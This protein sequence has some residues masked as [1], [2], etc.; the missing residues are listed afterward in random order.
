[1]VPQASSPTAQQA[2][3]V[4]F[5]TPTTLVPGAFTEFGLLLPPGTPDGLPAFLVAGTEGVGAGACPPWLDGACLDLAGTPVAALDEPVEDSEV[6]WE[7]RLP[8]TVSAPEITVQAVV[9]AP[10]GP[11][12]SAP[13]TIPVQGNTPPT[14]AT[15]DHP[16]VFVSQAPSLAGEFQINDLHGN[17]LGDAPATDQPVGG[18]LYRI[19]PGSDSPVDLLGL[20]EVAVRN[21][22]V[23]WDGTTILFSMK[24]GPL[25]NWQLYEVDADGTDLRRVVETP[26]NETEPLYLPDGRILFASDRLKILDPYEH[27]PVGQLFV[28]DPDGSNVQ[29]LT[30]DLGGDTTP[31]VL[32]DGRI[33]FTRWSATLDRPDLVQR[34]ADDAI[35]ELDVSRFL[36][37]SMTPDGDSDAH[38]L[39]GAQHPPDFGGG[40]SQARPL[41]DG[42]GRLVSTFSTADRWGAGAIL[43]FDPADDVTL[44]PPVQMV[45]QA[46][47]YGGEPAGSGG[48]FR[49][50][51][52]LEGGGFAVSFAAGR[53]F[54]E[55]CDGPAPEPPNFGLYTLTVDGE[56]ALI[57]DDPA[58]WEWEPVELAPR[59]PPPVIPPSLDTTQD[60]GIL[61]TLDVFLRERDMQGPLRGT[62]A[63]VDVY[64]A[65]PNAYTFA[66]FPGFRQHERALLGRVPIWDDG[67]FAARVPADT[68]LLWEMKDA[69]GNLLVR[70]R[71]WTSVRPGQTQTCAGCHAPDD[72]S[73]ARTS[74]H[75]LAAPT[76]LTEDMTRLIPTSLDPTDVCWFEWQTDQPRHIHRGTRLPE[77]R[78]LCYDG[79][80]ACD[81][82]DTLGTCTFEVGAC[83]GIDDT[84]AADADGN[85]LCDPTP[86]AALA[87][88][89]AHATTLAGSL[90][91]LGPDVS[92]HGTVVH[93]GTDTASA[94]SS[95]AAIV[96]PSGTTDTLDVETTTAAG[97]VRNATLEL[98]CR[99]TPT[100]PACEREYCFPTPRVGSEFPE[101]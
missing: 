73:T 92:A 27:H 79:D 56:R 5:E 11:Q 20:T 85:L 2:P 1:L 87:A 6:Y 51:Y 63:Y 75:A 37:W 84:R 7:F 54:N 71:F 68:P 8:P 18:T 58:M 16:I 76:D 101:P 48:R 40:F 72:G 66:A 3:P 13:V 9:L 57:Y 43:L 14:P 96:V 33:A 30:S 67:S 98:T 23:S 80:P 4:Q 52:P 49:D 35:G 28:M 61:N 81:H 78:L 99:P 77:P 22:E 53:V 41:L 15:W 100:P 64:K 97:E 89:G 70:E 93:A 34:A 39:F 10:S 50:A 69:D 24:V 88:S 36:I 55:C 29:Q 91:E 38:P 19:D 83:I 44:S 12:L 47:D 26:H 82:D 60:W 17:F 65:T 86:I 21:P 74:N 32:E 45:T 59:T 42:T 62:P 94:C 25:G 90:A 46:S 31:T 95:P